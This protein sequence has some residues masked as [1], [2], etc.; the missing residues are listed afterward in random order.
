MKKMLWLSSRQWNSLLETS[1]TGLDKHA[2]NDVG[3]W[4]HFKAEM[5]TS[6]EVVAVPGLVQSVIA[7]KVSEKQF[8]VYIT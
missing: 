7:R 8:L 4:S 1:K 3:L 5:L 2:E 6:P